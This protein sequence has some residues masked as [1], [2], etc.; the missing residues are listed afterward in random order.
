MDFSA[1]DDRHWSS[2][3][4]HS[5]RAVC[6][7][8]DRLLLNYHQKKILTFSYPQKIERLNDI[9]ISVPEIIHELIIKPRNDIEHY[10]TQ[11]EKKSAK[12]ALDLAGLFLEALDDELARESIISL[13][14]NI[15]Y[16]I[17]SNI[18]KTEITF[19][20]FGKN[21][22]LFVDIFQAPEEVKI[23]DPKDGEVRYACLNRF[24]EDESLELA[25]LLRKHHNQKSHGES[26]H[27][28]NVFKEIKHQAGI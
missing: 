21:P 3:I 1:G 7:I 9:G 13:S 27:S 10:Y 22:M 20:G 25:K 19:Q 14:W 11:P 28:V 6:C 2:A 8:I 26:V 12:R 5:K 23:V 15:M 4:S 18:N 16:S 24:N 17:Y